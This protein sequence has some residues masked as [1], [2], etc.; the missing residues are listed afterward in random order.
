MLHKFS[1]YFNTSVNIVTCNSVS[2]NVLKN[3]NLKEKLH[4]RNLSYFFDN[5][6]VSYT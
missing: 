6:S 2:A 1:L 5:V 3:E 4:D